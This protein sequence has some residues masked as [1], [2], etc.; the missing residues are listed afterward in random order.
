MVISIVKCEERRGLYEAK[1]VAAEWILNNF[2][3]HCS[4][5]YLSRLFLVDDRRKAPD[6]LLG[7]AI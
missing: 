5:Q 3:E 6:G 1:G 7:L 2:H 4:G